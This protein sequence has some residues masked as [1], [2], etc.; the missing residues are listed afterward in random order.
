[1][2]TF[3]NIYGLF[4]SLPLETGSSSL[5]NI[6]VLRLKKE[7]FFYIFE[8]EYYGFAVSNSIEDISTYL[9]ACP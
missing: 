6:S 2:P 3:L 8:I 9:E 5:P 1:M 4:F 7:V